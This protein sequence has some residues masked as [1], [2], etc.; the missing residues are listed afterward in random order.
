MQSQYVQDVP[1]GYFQVAA[2]GIDT[3]QAIASIS[4]AAIAI[5]LKGECTLLISCEAQAVRWRDDGT[6]PTAAVGMPL[7]VGVERMFPARA[8]NLQFISVVA[9]AILNV[10]VYGQTGSPG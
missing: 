3:A 2:G 7:A 10:T 4:A 9:G 8:K 6:A 5:F 1:L